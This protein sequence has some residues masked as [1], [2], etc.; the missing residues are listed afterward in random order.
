MGVGVGVGVG[1][2]EGEG[3]GLGLGSGAVGIGPGHP[4]ESRMNAPT[5]KTRI[6]ER[7]SIPM[8]PLFREPG[9]RS[10]HNTDP[11]E[12]NHG[13]CRHRLPPSRIRPAK[14]DQQ[15]NRNEQA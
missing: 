10:Q 8:D 9:D 6:Q 3:A 12:N 13:D 1:V 5:A 2:G 7:E 4:A 15:Q 11:A 14:V